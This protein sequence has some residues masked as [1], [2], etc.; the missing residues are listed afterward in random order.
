MIH[1]LTIQKFI[2][3]QVPVLVPGNPTDVDPQLAVEQNSS[4]S[5]F[6]WFENLTPKYQKSVQNLR[7][8]PKFCPNLNFSSL[9]IQ[10]IRFR[11]HK[12]QPIY[13]DA[14]NA[15]MVAKDN[16]PHDDSAR[17]LPTCPVQIYAAHFGLQP[18]TGSWN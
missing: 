17:L 8:S 3:D 7:F 5:Q 1:W 10:K 6:R 14:A 11:Y 16:L 18:G 4:A 12:D 13:V 9:E 2:C 15:N